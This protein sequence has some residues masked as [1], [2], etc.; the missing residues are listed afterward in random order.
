MRRSREFVAGPERSRT[1]ELSRTSGVSFLI[2]AGGRGLDMRQPF[3]QRLARRRLGFG[4]DDCK[5]RH[6]ALDQATIR[7]ARQAPSLRALPTQNTR[8]NQNPNQAGEENTHRVPT[9]NERRCAFV[10]VNRVHP[11]GRAVAKLGSWAGIPLRLSVGS[12]LLEHAYAKIGAPLGRWPG[13]SMRPIAR[14][15]YRWARERP[16]MNGPSRR[17]DRWDAERPIR[18]DDRSLRAPLTVC[19]TP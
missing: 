3:C 15:L 7:L 13:Y 17:A 8:S 1:L 2:G 4:R 19:R 5:E 14:M 10:A 9:R 18:I 12:G 16:T 11:R 6:P